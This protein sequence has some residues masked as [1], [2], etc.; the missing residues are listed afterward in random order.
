MLGNS[1]RLQTGYSR[2]RGFWFKIERKAQVTPAAQ[3]ER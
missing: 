2:L 3:S 1:N